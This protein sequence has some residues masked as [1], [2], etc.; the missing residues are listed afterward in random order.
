MIY[1]DK[2]LHF[3]PVRLADQSG[4]LAVGG[5]LKPERI[6]L[7]YQ[8]GVFP[9]FADEGPVLWWAPDPRFVLFPQDFK[10]SKSTRRLLRKN[11][12]QVT[13]DTC[14]ER[15]INECQ[16]IQRPGQDGTWISDDLKKSFIQIHE[17]GFAHSVEVW[18]DGDLVGGLYGTSLGGMYFGESMF[19]KVSNASK[20]GFVTLVPKLIE[21]GIKLIDCQVYTEY[22]EQ[23]GARHI[24]RESFMHNLEVLLDFDT[25]KGKWTHLFQV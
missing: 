2:K 25:L 10:M 8:K 3:P 11:V 19:S 7:A 20:I 4:V 12:F 21:R 16:N 13:F 14:F 17:N 1:I 24:P 6:M 5:D 15:V 18:K 9:W 23:F 22:L